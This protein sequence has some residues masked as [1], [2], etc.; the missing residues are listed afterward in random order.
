MTLSL[1]SR[2][3]TLNDTGAEHDLMEVLLCEAHH[4]GKHIFHTCV[5]ADWERPR[6]GFRREW[7]TIY[8]LDYQ[9]STSTWWVFKNGSGRLTDLRGRT[10]HRRDFLALICGFEVALENDWVIKPCR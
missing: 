5:R 9:Q 1:P 3:I 10:L 6:G 2:F 8:D 4:R 7:S